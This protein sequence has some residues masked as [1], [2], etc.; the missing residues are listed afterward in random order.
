MYSKSVPTSPGPV[1]SD[2]AAREEPG[3]PESLAVMVHLA[4]KSF[5][6]EPATVTSLGVC[7]DITAMY[8]GLCN[9][10]SQFIPIMAIVG[11]LFGVNME[12]NVNGFNYYITNQHYHG[13]WAPGSIC[14]N[15]GI[16]Y[17]MV[18]GLNVPVTIPHEPH[19]ADCYHKGTLEAYCRLNNLKFTPRWKHRLPQVMSAR[20][21]F[22]P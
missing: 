4:V 11:G 17:V 2:N 13:L 12:V 21:W 3:T 10:E 19:T 9:Q 20:L 6:L 15:S 18:K 16:W 8:K 7:N 5:R 22:I 14:Y 1:S